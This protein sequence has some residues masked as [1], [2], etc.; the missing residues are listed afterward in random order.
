MALHMR[1]QVLRALLA[2]AQGEIERHKVNV[3]IFLEHPVGVAEHPDALQTIQN[4]IDAIAKYHDQI[5]VINKYFKAPGSREI[6]S[7]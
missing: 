1:E 3:N 2:H 5:E 4:E 7:E 6:L